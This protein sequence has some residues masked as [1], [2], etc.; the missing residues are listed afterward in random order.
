M[1]YTLEIVPAANAEL[2]EASRWYDVQ[3]SGLG[4]DFL[5]CAEEAIDVIKRNPEAYQKVTAAVRRKL[6]ARFPYGIFFRLHKQR[7][8]IIAVLHNHRDPVSWRKRM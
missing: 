6:M 7:I 4:M 2:K 8:E 5:L 3:R 1:S